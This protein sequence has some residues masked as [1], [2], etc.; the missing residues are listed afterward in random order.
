MGSNEMF[1]KGS[2]RKPNTLDGRARVTVKKVPAE[3]FSYACVMHPSTRSS[4]PKEC[5]ESS[6][7]SA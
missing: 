2:D 5:A 1:G 3:L 4:L 6:K 7:G